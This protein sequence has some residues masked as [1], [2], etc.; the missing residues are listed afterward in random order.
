MDR[1]TS[2][3]KV[4]HLIVDNASSHDTKGVRELLESR[5]GRFVVHFAPAHASWRNLAERW[6]SEVTTKRIRRGSWSSVK[7]LERAIMDD[8]HHWNESGKR[9]VWTKSSR[10][11]LRSVRKATQDQ[12]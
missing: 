6:V 7:E 8:I 1:N 11:I 4:L 5:P 12:A 10:Q 3:R 9:F 2:K